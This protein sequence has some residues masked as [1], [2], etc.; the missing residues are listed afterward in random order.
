[1]GIYF[2]SYYV[3]ILLSIVLSFVAFYRGHKRYFPLLLAL[4][5]TIIVE[6]SVTILID[7]R[8]S[9]TW[10]YHLFVFVEY[11]MV[12]LYLRLAIHTEKIKRIIL[13]SIP[14]FIVISFL[15]SFFFS[16]FRGF[17]GIN[18]SIEGFLLF[19][20][21]MVLLFNLEVSEN[22]SVFVNPDLWI[23]LAF[24]IYEGGT[25]F[26]NGVY[27]RLVNLDE[28]TAIRLFSYIN[29]PLNIC[30]YTFINIGLICLIKKK[31]SIMQ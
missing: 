5:L 1:M 26:Y 15:I 7:K 30:L 19:I 31:R 20:F 28:A 17:P 29:R 6:G 18:L 21:C 9:F 2:I 8:L 16:H 14:V 27:T 10:I 3:L 4:L 11:A 13:V 23:A 22:D 25:F 24:M 12:V